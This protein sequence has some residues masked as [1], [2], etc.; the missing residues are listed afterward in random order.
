MNMLG[1]SIRLHFVLICIVTFHDLWPQAQG[2]DEKVLEIVV[3]L[4][5]PGL[6]SRPSINLHCRQWA[7][8]VQLHRALIQQPKIYA[9]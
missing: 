8:S 6:E 3:W 9:S 5:I 7:R 4:Q 2:T 1:L